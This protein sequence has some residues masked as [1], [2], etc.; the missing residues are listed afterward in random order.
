M[1]TRSYSIVLAV[2]GS[3]QGALALRALL[4]SMALLLL[5]CSSCAMLHQTIRPGAITPAPTPQLPS[6][7][8]TSTLTA[9]SFGSVSANGTPGSGGGSFGGSQASPG[10]D[11]AADYSGSATGNEDSRSCGTGWTQSQTRAGAHFTPQNDLAHRAFGFTLSADA[12]AKGGFW[13]SYISVPIIGHV[14]HGSNNTVATATSTASARM[15]LTFNAGVTEPDKLIIRTVGSSASG[16]NLVVKSSTGGVLPLTQLQSNDGVTVELA[17]PGPYTLTC[18]ISPGTASNG[19]GGAAVDQRQET[20]SVSV[21]S[22]RDALALGYG[23]PLMDTFRVPLPVQVTTADLVN[24]IKTRLFTDSGRWF[25]CRTLDCG[26]DGAKDL[27]LENPRV[28]VMGGNLVID[29]HL[30]GHYSWL[31]LSPGLT[32]DLR[33]IVEPFV[34]K[35]TIRFKNPSMELASRNALV[36]HFGPKAAQALVS[37][38]G[39]LTFDARPLIDKEMAKIQGKFPIKWGS[40]CLLLKPSEFNVEGFTMTTAP[41]EAIVVRFGLTLETVSGADCATA[42]AH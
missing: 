33:F 37:R 32:G 42:A 8:Y 7:D 2:G 3:R 15:D 31:F 13:R 25:P 5:G 30:S 26:D 41:V 34:D 4:S 17:A 11:T 35:N 40:A 10:A 1:K 38:V 9:A 23:Q 27:Y 16:A 29:A 12:Y 6:V 39:S 20:F 28:A 19:G 18:S 14:C 36:K 22:M 24:E 21:Q